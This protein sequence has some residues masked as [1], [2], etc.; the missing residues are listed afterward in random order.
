MCLETKITKLV[1][2]VER[3]TMHKQVTAQLSKNLNLDQS[4]NM[5][6]KS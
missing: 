4:N 6:F 3:F 2:L 5:Q 1:Y